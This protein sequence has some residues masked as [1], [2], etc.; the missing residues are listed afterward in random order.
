[1]VYRSWILKINI[2][3][4]PFWGR[5]WV[6]MV[7]CKVD[8]AYCHVGQEHYWVGWSR[9]KVLLCEDDQNRKWEYIRTEECV[10]L[11]HS[12]KGMMHWKI[13]NTNYSFSRL[14]RAL[15]LLH[16]LLSLKNLT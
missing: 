5:F 4:L 9:Y 11:F 13:F 15:N 3:A 10:H 2:K 7:G 6:V 16:F 1:M 14:S 12:V 8:P